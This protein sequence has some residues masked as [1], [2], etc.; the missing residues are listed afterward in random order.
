MVG[1]AGVEGFAPPPLGLPVDAGFFGGVI[2]GPFHQVEGWVGAGV[3]SGALGV[4]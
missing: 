1:V 2:R 4:P 3:E